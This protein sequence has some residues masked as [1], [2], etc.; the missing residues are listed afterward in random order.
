MCGPQTRK[1][2]WAGYIFCILLW[3][4]S[5]EIGI[6]AL[7]NLGYKF[8]HA[9]FFNSF[10]PL[11]TAFLLREPSGKFFSGFLF[12]FVLLFSLTRLGF[13]LDPYFG[14][15]VNDDN[16]SFPSLCWLQERSFIYAFMQQFILFSTYCMPA[17]CSKTKGDPHGKCWY[18]LIYRL[19]LRLQSGLTVPLLF[20]TPFLLM[21]ISL[22]T[23]LFCLLYYFKTGKFYLCV[24]CIFMGHHRSFWARR[25]YTREEIQCR[26][27]LGVG[28]GGGTGVER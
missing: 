18:L 27:P 3:G 26:C 7:G 4:N 23:F 2:S 20:Y 9:M 28:S 25:R 14:D 24:L 5:R 22:L 16:R 13:G 11:H 1:G 19:D 15:P 12:C 21:I 6:T 8:V 10:C 17:L